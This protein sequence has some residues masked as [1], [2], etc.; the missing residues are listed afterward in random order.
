MDTS[1]LIQKL[2]EAQ[3]L[4]I[5][6]RLKAFKF[7]E[8]NIEQ[9]LKDKT[10]LSLAD[11][12]IYIDILKALSKSPCPTASLSKNLTKLISHRLALLGCEAPKVLLKKNGTISLEG[13]CI[14]VG[15]MAYAEDI[16]QYISATRAT[17]TDPIRFHA[18][19][20]TLMNQGK[21]FFF[22]TGGDGL[23]HFQV[24]IIE[25]PEPVVTAKEFKLVLDS[26]PVV[27]LDFPT[28]KFGIQDSIL[29][30]NLESA[31]E[32]DIAPG[33]YK[34]QVHHFLFPKKNRSD[35][36]CDESSFYIVLSKTEDPLENQLQD[37]PALI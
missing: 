13:G 7:I 8:Y 17:E 31:L 15:D 30:K 1:N 29:Y 4:P 20:L 24:R 37:T 5:R 19:N 36:E 23:F 27:I 18:Y 35:S 10:S 22:G 14:A 11:I 25:A 16:D 3:R 34:C 12:D 26:T 6:E 21:I 32:I 2:D 28:G 33:R 9:A